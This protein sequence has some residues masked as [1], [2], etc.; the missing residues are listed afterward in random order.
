MAI[1]ESFKYTLDNKQGAIQQYKP[2]CHYMEMAKKLIRHRNE[3]KSHL[4]C[5]ISKISKIQEVK[6]IE[7]PAYE[8]NC[9]DTHYIPIEYKYCDVDS[10]QLLCIIVYFVRLYTHTWLH[11]HIFVLLKNK[12]AQSIRYENIFEFHKSSVLQRLALLQ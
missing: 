12:Y 7:N 10:I 3:K 5:H 6:E 4:S 8:E 2:R 1:F 9:S 11:F